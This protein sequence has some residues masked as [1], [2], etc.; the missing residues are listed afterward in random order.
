[1][2]RWTSI[3]PLLRE[4]PFVVFALC[5]FFSPFP[6][7][8]DVDALCRDPTIPITTTSSIDDID[9]KSFLFAPMRR[10]SKYLLS[11][12]LLLL[13]PNEKGEIWDLKPRNSTT[14]SHRKCKLPLLPFV[15]ADDDEADVCVWK[16]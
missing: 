5:C 4:F 7:D 9:K 3:L 6:I 11:P 10:C 13:F 15:I 16:G 1:M 2:K 12:L 8:V 14:F